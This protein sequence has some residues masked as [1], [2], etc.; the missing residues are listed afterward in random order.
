MTKS[1]LLPNMEFSERILRLSI[2]RNYGDIF[3]FSMV[4][5]ARK[6]K[7]K[8]KA[9]GRERDNVT[10]I[11]LKYIVSGIVRIAINK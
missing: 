2:G 8:Y 7:E 6:Q 9:R 4:Q 3:Y 10:I 5:I 11:A 1:G